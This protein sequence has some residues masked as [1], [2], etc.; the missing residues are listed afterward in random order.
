M[1]FPCVAGAVA[2]T[3]RAIRGTI[4]VGLAAIAGAVAAIALAVRR[5]T[6]LVFTGFAQAVSAKE[7]IEVAAA[8]KGPAMLVASVHAPTIGSYS[9]WHLGGPT[10]LRATSLAMKLFTWEPFPGDE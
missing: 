7:H 10:G 1:A 3:L 4:A 8:N 6:G 9:N 2:A 5:A